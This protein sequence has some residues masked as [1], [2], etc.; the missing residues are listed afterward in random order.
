[1]AT[2]EHHCLVELLSQNFYSDLNMDIRAVVSNHDDL[3]G[4]SEKFATPYHFVP[5]AGIGRGEHEKRIEEV[6]SDYD[7]E[8]IVL[9]KYMRVLSK[10][11]V[12]RYSQKVI[13]IHHSFLPAFA[14]ANPYRQ[15]YA[16]GVKLI[17]ATAHFVTEKL[18]EGPIISQDVVDINHTYGVDEIKKAGRDME[19][20]V[21][22]R[23]LR[24]V[25]ED[26]LFVNG[27]KTIVF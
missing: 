27:N 22:T 17:G 18:D 24:L 1:M 3:R 16:R 25:S 7:F 14:G 21:L 10:D 19:S 23:A 4:I 8:Y 11:F 6:L 20:L 13:N 9:A 15:A 26:R 12:N 2:K 5:S